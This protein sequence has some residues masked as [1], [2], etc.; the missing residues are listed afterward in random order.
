MR[1][2]RRVIVD[3]YNTRHLRIVYRH[4]DELGERNVPVIHGG[5]K[6]PLDNGLNRLQVFAI[7]DYAGDETRKSTYGRVLMMNG[8]P[9]AW[10]FTLKKSCHVDL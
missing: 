4:P 1:A 7:S 3:L 2:A 9:S 8:G 10:S 5:A 6:H